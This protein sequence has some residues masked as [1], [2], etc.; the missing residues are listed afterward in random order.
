MLKYLSITSDIT[1]HT[2]YIYE[3]KVIF[4]CKNYGTFIF[5]T[6]FFNSLEYPN[7]QCN[8][9]YTLD[10]VALNP[11]PASAVTS[12]VKSLSLVSIPVM[13]NY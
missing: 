1:Q 5:F 10:Q 8:I 12:F 9:E 2:S 4:S 3:I 7:K 6:D 13:Y 11:S